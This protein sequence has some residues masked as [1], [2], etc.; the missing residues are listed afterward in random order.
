MWSLVRTCLKTS[1]GRSE[2]SMEI[3]Q[4]PKAFLYVVKSEKSSEADEAFFLFLDD[5]AESTAVAPVEFGGG[6]GFRV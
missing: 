4:S 6:K 3:Q 5:D 2:R 1:M